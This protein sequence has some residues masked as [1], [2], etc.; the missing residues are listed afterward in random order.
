MK[1]TGL[2]QTL[3]TSIARLEKNAGR[4][5]KRNKDRF[6]RVFE[7]KENTHC[8]TRTV[9]LTSGTKS[10]VISYHKESW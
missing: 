5:R 3:T 7:S 8:T 1:N 9:T 2:L 4:G 6:R 10:V